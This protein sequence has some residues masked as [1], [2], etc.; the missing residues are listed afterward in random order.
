M[1]GS[2]GYSSKLINAGQIK[3]RGCE[4]M[5]NATPLRT[6]D[7]NWDVNLNWGLNLTECVMLD[8]DIFL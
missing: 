4:L 3:S 5:V 6:N 8:S 7:W 1:P 2:S